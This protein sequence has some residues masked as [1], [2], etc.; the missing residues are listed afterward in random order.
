MN[1]MVHT[2]AILAAPTMSIFRIFIP[3]CAC[4]QTI[5]AAPTVT[6]MIRRPPPCARNNNITTDAAIDI[7]V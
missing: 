4:I 3:G 5:S 7:S 1:C 6:M 2:M